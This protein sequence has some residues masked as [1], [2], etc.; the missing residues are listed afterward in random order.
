MEY[1]DIKIADSNI[2]MHDVLLKKTFY[3]TYQKRNC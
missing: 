1:G 2:C 3:R